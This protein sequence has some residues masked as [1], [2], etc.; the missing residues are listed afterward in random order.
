VLKVSQRPDFSHSGQW[1]V[2]TENSEGKQQKHIFDAVMI[3]IGHH[4]HPNMPLHDFTG[5]ASPFITT[6]FKHHSL[7][8]A[9]IGTDGA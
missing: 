2:E 8:T 9:Q 1:D 6:L 5:I 3:C 7:N 4:C